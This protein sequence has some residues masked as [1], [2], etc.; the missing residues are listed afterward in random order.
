VTSEAEDSNSVCRLSK[1]CNY[2]VQ[3]SKICLLL[4]TCINKQENSRKENVTG[5]SIRI[6]RISND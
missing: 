5:H 1:E 6:K 4:T 2:E 3:S